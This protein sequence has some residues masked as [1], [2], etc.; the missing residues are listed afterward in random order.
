M[1]VAAI[2]TPETRTRSEDDMLTLPESNLIVNE[3]ETEDAV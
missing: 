3:C 1:S 2:R